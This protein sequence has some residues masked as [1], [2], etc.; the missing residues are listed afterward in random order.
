MRRDELHYNL[1]PELI[2]QQPAE[3]RDASR[4]LVV[5]RADGRLEHRVFRDLPEY[6]RARDCLAVNNTAV[7]PAR[8]YCRRQSGGRIEGLFLHREADDAWRVL[9][10]PSKRLG[11]GETVVCEGS[12]VALALLERGDRG[13]WRV[14]PTPAVPFDELL[15]QIGQTPLPPYI[16][17]DPAPT[18][19]DRS[20]YQTVYAAEAGAVAAPTAGLHF[21]PGLLE[22]LKSLGVERAELTLHV[23]LGTFA[24]VEAESLEQH[25]IHAEWFEVRSAALE[26]L[27][28]ARD[29][30]GRIIAVGTTSARVL[31]TLANIGSAPPA[32]AEQLARH[33]AG[34]VTLNG[35]DIAS[36]WTDT[37]LYPPYR[38]RNVDAMITN[39]H[40]PGSTLIAM[41]MALLG[42]ELL[43]KAYQAAIAERYRF[44]SYGDAMLIL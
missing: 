10:K 37:F 1:P 20:R 23:G 16:H 29:A 41:I 30:G 39:F 26:K 32:D 7:V 31:E 27:T 33:R 11:V 21:T 17:R 34:R 25:S 36:G 13:A 9:L 38:F 5:H 15:A 40:L 24:P 28:A 12:T 14:K 18:P 8:F 22:R 19:D 35:R 43:W 6:V 4:L 42:R 3:P 2:A 44:Y